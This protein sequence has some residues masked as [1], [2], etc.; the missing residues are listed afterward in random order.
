MHDH[1]RRQI[2]DPEVVVLVV[3]QP[4][5][6]LQRLFLCLFAAHAAGGFQA[7][8][9][10]EHAGGGLHHVLGLLRLGLVQVAMNLLEHHHAQGHQGQ[11]RHDQ[12]QPQTL[13]DGHLA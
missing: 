2:V 1:D 7:L 6:H 13:T 12:D 3:A 9:V 10:S 8:V 5:N 11:H 4:A